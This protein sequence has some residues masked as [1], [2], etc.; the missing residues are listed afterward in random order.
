M[1][2]E[3]QIVMSIF[4][5]SALAYLALAQ[6]TSNDKKDVA[7]TTT[8]ATSKAEDMIRNDRDRNDRDGDDRNRENWLRRP[9][10]KDPGKAYMGA[11]NRI[12]ASPSYTNATSKVEEMIRNDR[13]RNDRDGDERNIEIRT[14]KLSDPGAS[15][16]DTGATNRT[17]GSRSST[18]AASKADNTAK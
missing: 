6:D 11:T 12:E 9:P 17:E 4:A 15:H 14:R 8:N 1:K 5:A 3:L 7:G 18:N 2:R 13:D 16:A 10:A